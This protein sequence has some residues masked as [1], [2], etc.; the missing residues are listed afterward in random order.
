MA[1]ASALFLGLVSILTQ[2][3]PPNKIAPVGHTEKQHKILSTY[4]YNH[5]SLKLWNLHGFIQAYLESWVQATDLSLC[6]SDPLP[7]KITQGAAKLSPDTQI[8]APIFIDSMVLP[9]KFW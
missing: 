2:P 4:N 7:D 1:S 8:S 6:W 9:A 3:F 5:N